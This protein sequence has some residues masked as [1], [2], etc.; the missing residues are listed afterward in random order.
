MQA[1]IERISE[2]LAGRPDAE[3]MPEFNRRLFARHA[4]EIKLEAGLTVDEAERDVLEAVLAEG[5]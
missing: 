5:E 3:W 1:A 2:A 4:L